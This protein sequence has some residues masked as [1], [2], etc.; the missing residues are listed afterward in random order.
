MCKFP[1]WNQAFKSGK[2]DLPL[3][4]GASIF[5]AV[6]ENRMDVARAV[7]TGPVDTPYALGC[8][9]FDIFFPDNYP[10]EAPLLKL[11]TTGVSD[12]I[13]S[14]RALARACFEWCLDSLEGCFHH[15]RSYIRQQ[16]SS[17][18]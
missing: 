9:A 13:C 2:T 15:A 18:R 12:S 17:A 8:F 16:P 10:N 4:P 14:N 1:P 5:L 6:D 7:I 3:H 11:I